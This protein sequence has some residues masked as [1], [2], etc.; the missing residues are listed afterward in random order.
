MAMIFPFDSLAQDALTPLSL[1]VAV[2]LGVAFGFVLERSGFGRAPK[3]VAQFYLTDMTVF[4]VMFTAVVVAALGSSLLSAV[5]LLDLKAV[6]INYPSFLWP[7]V[8]GGLLVGAGFVTS[9]YCPGTGVVAAASGKLDGLVTILGVV[10]GGVLFAESGAG[11]SSFFES[12]KLGGS[13]LYKLLGLPPL[14]LALLIAVVAVGC[15]VVAGKI[16]RKST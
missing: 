6:T 1:L 9:G 11:A 8:V 15:F 13:F 2:L 7:M 16:E 12:G 4:R 3:L 5:G 14:A 10:I